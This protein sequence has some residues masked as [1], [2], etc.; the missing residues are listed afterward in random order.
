MPRSV[1][2]HASRRPFF[3]NTLFT[4]TIS[5]PSSAAVAIA[6]AVLPRK[7]QTDAK[8][9]P[10]QVISYYSSSKPRREGGRNRAVLVSVPLAKSPPLR[11]LRRGVRDSAA[12]S[13]SFCFTRSTL[14]GTEK[15]GIRFAE[16]NPQESM[17]VV[18]YIDGRER[19]S[20]D[21]RARR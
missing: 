21:H 1:P 10:L 12:D 19:G 4:L 5:Q 17:S 9:L 8:L 6:A 16:K 7:I 20:D 14:H 3:F 11:L 18:T 2:A 13:F 15:E